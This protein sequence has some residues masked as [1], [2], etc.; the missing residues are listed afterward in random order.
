MCTGAVSM[1]LSITYMDVRY[2]GNAGAVSMSY[3][4]RRIPAGGMRPF[5]FGPGK[6]V[7]MPSQCT[8]GDPW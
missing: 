5:N 2:V 3:F 6:T 4:I 1:D 7:Q 8:R